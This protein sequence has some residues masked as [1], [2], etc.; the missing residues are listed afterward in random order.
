MMEDD[1][2]SEDV[3][4]E[5]KLNHDQQQ[6]QSAKAIQSFDPSKMSGY[7]SPQKNFFFFLLS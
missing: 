1:S 5:K 7:L 3:G 2:C 6:Y 4:F